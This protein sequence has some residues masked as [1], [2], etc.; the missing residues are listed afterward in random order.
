MQ[1]KRMKEES[2]G[3]ALFSIGLAVFNSLIPIRF[4]PQGGRTLN[5]AADGVT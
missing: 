5:V 1:K 2:E 3:W 4:N